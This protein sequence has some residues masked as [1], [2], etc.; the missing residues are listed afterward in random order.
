MF[1]AEFTWG[2]LGK[3]TTPKRHHSKSEDRSRQSKKLH[4][5]YVRGQGPSQYQKE[6]DI[7]T[8][9]EVID[10]LTPAGSIDLPQD[11]IE[12]LSVLKTWCIQCVRYTI[13]ISAICWKSMMLTMA[14]SSYNQ[15][16][17]LLLVRRTT[18]AEYKKMSTTPMTCFMQK[19]WR[20]FFVLQGCIEAACKWTYV[21]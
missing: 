15:D 19:I 10:V 4:V 3:E 11:A 5:D 21:L 18:F 2:K 16:M 17:S 12:A 8:E 9:D 14:S 6:D 7:K 1:Y 20:A 13:S